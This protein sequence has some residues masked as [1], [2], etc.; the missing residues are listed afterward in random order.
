M[1]IPDRTDDIRK[2]IDHEHFRYRTRDAA[3]S[4]KNETKLTP[5]WGIWFEGEE[6][7]LIRRM[8]SDFRTF[9]KTC[10]KVDL[11]PDENAAPRIRLIAHSSRLDFDRLDPDIEAFAITAVDGEILMEAQHERGLLHGVHYLERMMADRGAPVVEIGK[12][13]RVP[14][15]MPRISNSIFISARQNVTDPRQFS[16]EY[17]GL[18]SHFGV[19]GLH[20]FTHLWDFCKSALLPEL[21]SPGFDEQMEA[22]TRLSDR[23][24][25]Y[26]IDI[27]LCIVTSPL[28]E[29]HPVFANLAE[30]RGASCYT[31]LD[32][33]ES[34]HCLCSGRE[35]SL[36]FFE[37][38]IVN[39]FTASPKLAGIVSIIGGEGFNH[40]F[41]RPV[42]PYTGNS[43]CP[44]C[45]DIDPSTG[46]ATLVNRCA[47]ALKKTGKHKVYF[48]WPYS[49][50]TWSGK[51]TTQQSWLGYLDDD[52]SVVSNFDTGSPDKVNGDGVHLFD[53][54][55][56]TIGQSDHFERQ[57]ARLASLKKPIY[58]KVETSVTP[59]ANFVPYIPVHHRWHR[60]SQAMRN[61][62]VEGFIGQWRFYG[63]N[64]CLPEELQYHAT[65]NPGEDTE[66]LLRRIAMRDFEIQANKADKVVRGWQH[67]SDAWDHFPYSSMLCGERTSYFRGPLYMGPAHPLIF[68]S[69]NS[70]GLGPGFRKIRGDAIEGG[71]VDDEEDIANTAPPHYVDQLLFVFPYG[72]ERFLELIGRCRTGW[73]QGLTILRDTLGA[74][75][76]DEARKELGV[77]E[78]VG[79]HLTTV[80]NVAK[81][82][83]TRDK[84]WREHSDLEL[85]EKEIAGLQSIV[86]SEIENARRSLPILEQD[87]RIAFNHCYGNPYSTDMVR[88]KIRQCEFVMNEELRIFKQEVRF[89]IWQQ[90]P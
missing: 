21:T 14:A 75:P 48:A 79:I 22:L 53:Y 38:C 59:H 5:E 50:F 11:R 20:L 37:E 62:P 31:I 81:F 54:N 83:R 64:G 68:D 47:A 76:T 32:A 61:A 29:S 10:M 15:F 39:I 19:N 46:V 41:T 49:A 78:I 25:Q 27:Y 88:E 35:K 65:W 87:P 33:T 70:Y 26:G 44:V 16:D 86:A 12:I 90:F 66:S 67:L 56:K 1:T 52:V 74:S 3:P 58:T 13:E 84:L 28:P 9:C 63:M 34:Q 7:P 40:C 69:Q 85:F 89:H 73:E 6:T 2:F 18:M 4:R 17:L 45:R 23:A 72:E 77:C 8:L 43:S 51:D 71:Q 36:E 55:I 82:Y 57:R 80:E 42:T 24:A 60:R 30:V